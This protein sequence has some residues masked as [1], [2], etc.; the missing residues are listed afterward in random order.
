MSIPGTNIMAKPIVTAETGIETGSV[1]LMRK[2]M[3][4][5]M[6]PYKPEQ[7]REI[8]TTGVWHPER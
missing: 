7:W 6:L 1:R 8:V 3:A 5:K 4:G 2:Y